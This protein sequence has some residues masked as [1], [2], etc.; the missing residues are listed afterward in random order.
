MKLCRLCAERP[1]APSRLR[2]HDY[3]CSRC[4]HQTPAMR[5]TNRRYF[6]SDLRRA[7]AKRSNDKRIFIGR[8]YYSSAPTLEDAQ[9]INAHIK[10]RR[11]AFIERLAD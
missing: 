2:E 9:R 11:H 6:Q 5:E 10:D 7:V 8:Q 1:V 3:R 4:R